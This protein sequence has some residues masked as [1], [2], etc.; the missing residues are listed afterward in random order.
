MRFVQ[1]VVVLFLA[2]VLIGCSSVPMSTLW[3]MRGF[4]PED[5]LAINANE[6]AARVSISEAYVP[7]FESVGLNV[8]MTEGDQEWDE[9]FELNLV[10]Q[11]P[12]TV[13][14][15]WFSA[16]REEMV[17]DLVLAEEAIDAFRRHQ[18]VYRQFEP[19]QVAA[20]VNMKFSEFPED[21]DSAII[22]I[23]LRLSQNDG[24]FPLIREAVLE[25][26]SE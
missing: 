4:G 1:G 2:A 5:F 17:Y 22:S 15:G 11:Y 6:L 21:R 7:D 13:P 19:R 8:R 23:E 25:F 16:D 26:K 18:D 24:Y 14:G 10:E 3:Q 12:R 9:R 20:S